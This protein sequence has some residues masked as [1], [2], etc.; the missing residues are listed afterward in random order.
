MKVCDPWHKYDT[1]LCYYIYLINSYKPM[2]FVDLVL[3]YGSLLFGTR[4]TKVPGSILIAVKNI[5]CKNIKIYKQ[6]SKNQLSEG[7]IRVTT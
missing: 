1:E 6:Q 4:V 7:S 3:Y 5:K 2:A